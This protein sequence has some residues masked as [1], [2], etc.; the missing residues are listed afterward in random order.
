MV[1]ASARGSARYRAPI[2]AASLP[3]AGPG[4][5]D[6]ST[7]APAAPRGRECVDLGTFTTTP[8]VTRNVCTTV[9]QNDDRR[10]KAFSAQP[11]CQSTGGVKR[12]RDRRATAA[13]QRTKR[14]FGSH[15]R[16]RGRQNEFGT[17][18]PESDQRHLIA[19]DVAI[20]QQ[21]FHRTFGFRQAMQS[22]RARRIDHEDR[23]RF[24]TLLESGDSKIVTMDMDA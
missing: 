7:K 10:A 24:T 11:V 12:G 16:A 1:A 8:A 23:R 2:S 20:C 6:V 18:A 22:R 5:G 3:A 21:Q 15:E 14:P 19:T 17:F 13:G 4:L 9:G